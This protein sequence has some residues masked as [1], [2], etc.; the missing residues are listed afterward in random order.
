MIF[1]LELMNPLPD[2]HSHGGTVPSIDF[3]PSPEDYHRVTNFQR[4]NSNAKVQ[5]FMPQR[6]L[7]LVN[8]KWINQ[9]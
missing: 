1:H 2:I 8:N 4:E 6:W 5:L 3:K 9:K 7:D